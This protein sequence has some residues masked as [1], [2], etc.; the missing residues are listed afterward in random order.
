M[1]H[2]D[3]LPIILNKLEEKEFELLSWGDTDGYFSEI[4]LFDL[5]ESV[6]PSIEP[7]DLLDELQEKSMIVLLCD[8]LGNTIG[9]RSRMAH[10]VHL[11]RNLRQWMHNQKLEASKSLVSDFRFLRRPRSYPIRNISSD[12]FIAHCAENGI[13]DSIIQLSLKE[14]IG[15][16]LLSG[17][18]L[19]ATIRT[20]LSWDQHKKRTKYPTATITCSGTGSGKT[21]AFYL[22]ALSSIVKDLSE[23]AARRVRAL[24]LYPRQ[25]LLKDQFNET[26]LAC[27]KL[28]KLTLQHAKR[29]I[30]IGAL[31]GATPSEASYALKKGQH[32]LASELLKCSTKNCKGEMRWLKEDIERDIEILKCSRCKNT[33]A[34]DE[35][36]L[37]RR[38]MESNPPD[39]VFTTTE[40]LNQ[41]LGHPSRQ[42]LFGIN[43]TKN[44]P[45]VLLDEVH[46]YSGT[47]GAHTAFLLRRW[48]KI[49][50][51]APHFVGLSATLSDAQNFFSLLTG[52]RE[53]SVML[54][55][56]EETEIEEEG[57]EYLIALRGDPISQ[58]ALLSTTI[59][60]S[61]LTRRILDRK[62]E[63]SGTWGN[64]TFIFTDDLDVKNRLFS[65]LA[66]AEGYK[67]ERGSLIEHQA[68]PLAQLRNPNFGEDV[69]FEVMSDLGQDWSALKENGFSLNYDDKANISET[70]SQNPGVNDKSDVVVA[71]ASLEVG[72]NDSRVGAV[73]QHKAPRNIA[74]YLQRK[75]R[76]GRTR[77]MRPWT[78]IVLSEFGKDRETFQHYEKLLEPEIKIQNLPTNNSHVQKMQGAMATMDWLSIKI[79]ESLWLLL[80]K[81]TGR[82]KPKLQDALRLIED[83]IQVGSRYQDELIEYVQDALMLTEAEVN[84][85][86]WQSPRSILLEFLPH[87]RQLI[88]TSWSNWDP[89]KNQLHKWGLVNP[90]WGSPTPEYVPPNLFSDLNIPSLNIALSRNLDNPIWEGMLLFQG[91]KEFAPGRISKRF[92]TY[93]GKS[94]DWLIPDNFSPTTQMH[95]TEI[96]F[97]IIQ[98]FGDCIS[99]LGEYEVTD[100]QKKLKVF[101]PFNIY[102]KSLFNSKEISE[103]SN[104]QLKWH[105]SFGEISQVEAQKPPSG[106]VWS[107]YLNYLSFFTHNSMTPLEITRYTTG[108]ECEFKFQNGEKAKVN[109]FWELDDASVGIG[110]KLVVD[111]AK[112][113]FDISDI[114]IEAWVKDPQV[115]MSLRTAYLQDCIKSSDLCEKNT[116]LSD[117]VYECLLASIVI[118]K[119]LS[120]VDIKTAIERVASQKSKL[121]LSEMPL[122]LFQQKFST[123]DDN[124]DEPLNIKKHK[125]QNSIIEKLNTTTVAVELAEMAKVLY[126]D[127][128][129]IPGFFQWARRVLANTLSAGIYQA[130][131]TAMPNIDERSLISD[132]VV[133]E[134]NDRITVWLS[135]QDS[136]GNG[137]ITQFQEIYSEDPF[138]LLNLISLSFEAGDY[139]QLDS[140]LYSLLEILQNNEN[141]GSALQ[142]LRNSNCYE[143][144]IVSNKS[145]RSLLIIEGF[146]YSHSF[147]AVLHSRI[148]KSGS[149]FESD[150]R[151]LSYL[152]T[153]RNLEESLGIEV[154][155]NIISLL[156]AIEDAPNDKPS[157]IFDR[158]C[159]IQSVLWPRGTSVRQSNFAFYNAFSGGIF[160]SER[161]LAAKLSAGDMEEV[162][163]ND[164]DWLGQLHSIIS[165][166]GRVILRVSRQEKSSISKALAQVHS[167]PVDTNGLFFYPRLKTI[168]NKS[169]CIFLTL[170]L[171]E[172]II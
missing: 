108:S 62:E 20:L 119:T 42:K 156:I 97:N 112:F 134:T 99:E 29:K 11:Y 136:G 151:L 47:H 23:D 155:M 77:K 165:E 53:T 40:M 72:F 80:N 111:A 137:V 58:T 89:Q 28:D 162:S 160:R 45:L 61:M 46:T 17:F 118:E 170:E 21:M 161:L 85:V 19:R 103:T 70:S 148:V 84:S 27:R 172:A 34:D 64:K 30:R 75:G 57:A 131:C 36:A 147:S 43:T 121:L 100:G 95:N 81:P 109:F 6:Y 50:N 164:K 52:T 104:A 48:M 37:T 101:K 4:E 142:K 9:Y 90:K 60:A 16:F 120:K 33:V 22:P 166:K 41:N 115:T 153:W 7:D 71:T 88:D 86:F 82:L 25:E 73:I 168:K 44:I 110:T 91:L 13:Y 49:S 12:S 54:I 169:G 74:S 8:S 135:E 107:K 15:T 14:Q 106:T 143:E 163:L 152:N 133:S 5:F 125:L 171:A 128:E 132:A 31:F 141:I 123:E 51:S 154:P 24:A 94:S 55:E 138:R 158:S 114:D 140:D 1:N 66:D 3:E 39:I 26:W 59:Q 65:Q 102:P 116:F 146:D 92:S 10:A 79:S 18:Q 76:A 87:I 130:A 124:D 93:S 149:S 105:S 145:L 157:S 122:F 167:T 139:E 127:L 67:L 35:V 69:S 68:G 78:V 144:R 83:V 129:D 96:D 117:W 98:A 56:P 126:C 38:S 63:S 2:Q 113:E 159:K 32:Y 150:K